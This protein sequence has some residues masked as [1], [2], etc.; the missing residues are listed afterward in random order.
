KDRPRSA[1]TPRV[2]EDPG[3]PLLGSPRLNGRCVLDTNVIWY[4]LMD[5]AFAERIVRSYAVHPGDTDHQIH[6]SPIRR[7]REM[8]KAWESSSGAFG[9][10]SHTGVPCS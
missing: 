10:R 6:R 1:R 5:T 3:T 9:G 4:S 7:A 2:L 8:R